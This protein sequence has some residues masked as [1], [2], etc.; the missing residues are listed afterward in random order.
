MSFTSAARQVRDPST[1]PWL[2]LSSIRA[3][4]RSY[5]SLTRTPYDATLQ[6]FGLAQ[7]I[8]DRLPPPAEEVCREVLNVVERARNIYLDRLR[9]VERNR[10][11]AKM[12]GNR[13]LS[14]AERELLRT[15]R[16]AARIGPVAAVNP[17][18][19]AGIPG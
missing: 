15:I 9:S 2:R 4:V 5:C 11:R 18:T 8:H 12:R 13:Q 1:P 16:E 14:N 10:I 6:H 17:P 3:C 19:A 7:T